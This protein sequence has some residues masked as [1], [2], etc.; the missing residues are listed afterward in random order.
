MKVLILVCQIFLIIGCA[1]EEL[2]LPSVEKNSKQEY[3]SLKIDFENR[4]KDDEFDEISIHTICISGKQKIETRLDCDKS[5]WR[6][7]SKK[8]KKKDSFEVEL[9]SGEYFAFLSVLGTQYFESFKLTGS[10]KN[11]IKNI[12]NSKG[13]EVKFGWFDEFECNPLKIAAN[14]TTEIRIVITEYHESLWVPS[15]LIGFVTLG[16]IIIPPSVRHAEIQVNYPT[17]K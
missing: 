8:L 12:A 16:L 10:F 3:G 14:K 7:N 4:S 15:I 13:C 2:K 5:V 9:P 17:S 6:V 11:L 1:T